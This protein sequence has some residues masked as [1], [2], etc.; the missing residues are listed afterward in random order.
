MPPDLHRAAALVS[1]TLPGVRLYHHGQLEGARVK[2]PV[3]LARRPAERVDESL[4]Q[5]YRELLELAADPV[6]RRGAWRPIDAVEAWQGNPSHGGF[7]A[8]AW[9]GLAAG[10]PSHR[11]LVANLATHAAQCRISVDLP[12]LVSRRVAVREIFATGPT[13]A[14]DSK[15][16]GGRPVYLRDGDQ[17]TGD[18]IF[19]ELPPR[20][21]QLFALESAAR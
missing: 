17:L 3:Q 9:D 19:F 11:L 21:A 14:G 8:G 7:V 20:T 16:A 2:I 12:G 6:L 5:F 13:P 18:G 4:A 10:S 15:S 1:M